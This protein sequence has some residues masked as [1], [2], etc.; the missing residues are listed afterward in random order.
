MDRRQFVKAAGVGVAGGAVAVIPLAGS[1]SANP[2]QL[3]CPIEDHYR[4]SA[5]TQEGAA[6]RLAEHLMDEHLPDGDT[7]GEVIAQVKTVTSK[8]K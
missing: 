4:T 6:A 5:E 2:I 1:A 7:L 8:F 3:S